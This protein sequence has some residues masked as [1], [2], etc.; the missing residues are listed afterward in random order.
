MGQPNPERRRGRFNITT[1]NHIEKEVNEQR[2][3]T[4]PRSANHRYLGAIFMPSGF[5]AFKSLPGGF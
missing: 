3:P 1:K 2:Q 5:Q 4:K